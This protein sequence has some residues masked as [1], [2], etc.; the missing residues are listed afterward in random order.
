MHV[1]FRHTPVTCMHVFVVVVYAVALL[2]LHSIRNNSV[3]GK[4]KC[5]RHGK[6]VVS[7]TNIFVVTFLVYDKY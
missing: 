5:L 1:G 2:V 7:N 4:K 6:I 3:F